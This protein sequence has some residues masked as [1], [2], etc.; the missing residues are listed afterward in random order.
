[1]TQ[2]E[3]QD[4]A[5]GGPV[6][7]ESISSQSGS[8]YSEDD[9]YN[10][11]HE[12]ITRSRNW[13][14]DNYDVIWAKTIQSYYSIR[15]PI[16]KADSQPVGMRERETMYASDSVAILQKAA[17]RIKRQERTD[18]LPVLWN[19]CQRL[20]ARVNANIP[21]IT[22]RGRN[23]Q[24]SE[25]VSQSL[26]YYWD[27]AQR[28]SRVINRTLTQAWLTG[29]TVNRWTWD[30][31]V[32]KRRIFV[33]PSHI[34][35]DQYAAVLEQYEPQLAP[36]MEALVQ[37]TGTDAN[38]DES[39]DALMGEAVNVLAEQF[40]HKGRLPLV[41][42]ERGYVGPSAKFIYCG[43]LYPEPEYETLGQAAYVGEFMRV[44]LDWFHALFVEH[45]DT[46]PGLQARLNRLM[47]EKPNGSVRTI[48]GDDEQLRGRMYD[49]MARV[50]AQ[51]P[52]TNSDDIEARWNVYRIDY[53]GRG[54]EDATVEY[55]CEGVWLGHF[56]Y[57]YLLS[58]GGIALTEMRIVESIL[59][60]PGDTPAH[61][62]LPLADM[63]AQSVLQ[64]YDLLDAISRPLIWTKDPALFNNPDQWIRNTSGFRVILSR[65]GAGSFGF[66]QSGPAIAS[67][68]ATLSGSDEPMMKIIQSTTGDT[69]L[70]GMAEI[71]PSQNETAT[72]AK[73]LQRQTDLLSGQTTSM[74]VQYVGAGAEMCKQLA[75]SE[76]TEDLELN[77]A[78]YHSSH[79]P[80]RY[81]RGIDDPSVEASR[82]TVEPEDFQDD[83][84]LIVDATSIFPEAKEQK[85]AEAD[86]LYQLAKENETV[87]NVRETLKDLLIVMGKG[88][89]LD[90]YLLPEQP[91][92]DPASMMEQ[93]ANAGNGTGAQQ[94]EQLAGPAQGGAGPIPPAPAP[95][96]PQVPGA[97][98]PGNIPAA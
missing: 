59:G 61:R 28:K 7:H 67:A 86:A 44:G 94:N 9:L 89:D 53:P 81:V 85:F 80:S 66:E 14:A 52:P 79:G 46:D 5:G 3:Q 8:Q 55:I 93:L 41:Y 16:L 4:L 91:P 65:G 22:C 75:R 87:M 20:V 15:E 36:I 1:M 45:G 92:I 42:N 33:R 29:M 49:L 97:P 37:E 58:E 63:Y 38:D 98:S 96:V 25:R 43:D 34:T 73:L 30:D 23:I 12:R 71:D 68:M 76:L 40:G 74:F 64:R 39:M 84:E 27:K 82:T 32:S 47:E 2:S 35:D 6:P 31:S 56:Y 26:M 77:D 51:A 60:G 90:R 21:T 11:A 72:G 19:A 18:G 88:K 62:I 48:G 54:G 17:T 50:T 69:N 70:T 13:R 24:R 95:M 83:G 10:I 78:N 57:P